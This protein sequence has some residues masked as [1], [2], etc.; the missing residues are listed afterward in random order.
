MSKFLDMVADPSAYDIAGK[1][2]AEKTIVDKAGKTRVFSLARPG[3]F[4]GREV[5]LV[6]DVTLKKHVEEEMLKAQKLESLGIL[7]GGIAHDFNNLLTSLL[8]NISIAKA[9]LNPESEARHR[10]DETERASNKAI[11]LTQQLLTF[12]KGGEPI[13]KICNMAELIRDACS[14]SLSGSNVN[15]QFD[16]AENL[17]SAEVDEGQINRVINNLIINAQQAMPNGGTIRVRACNEAVVKAGIP[18]LPSGNYVKISVIDEGV[19]IKDEDRA[20]IFDPYFSTKDTGSGLGLAAV[21]SII[22]RHDGHIMVESTPGKG[23][24][25]VFY[26]PSSEEAAHVVSKKE[27]VLLKGEGRILVMDDEREIRELTKAMLQ[28]LGYQADVA[29]DGAQAVE[30]YAEAMGIKKPYDA[31][32]LDLTVPG[33]MSGLKARNLIA[34]FDP[35][36]KA[37]ASSGYS[38]DAV[39]ANHDEYGFVECAPKP[40]NIHALGR[41]LRNVLPNKGK[42]A[43]EN[44]S[45]KERA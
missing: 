9:M 24:T 30:M 41:I 22:K 26:L 6:Q 39:L 45:T 13:K 29:S 38:N 18:G 10:L 33:G 35:R 32:I 17:W 19:G 3:I 44:S 28:M 23:A 20:R 2:L 4:A 1:D 42:G 11:R 27:A 37:I 15:C 31:V 7:A 36:V 16:I 21:F 8:G 34:E 25:F 43:Q 40:Y 14:F 5:L 12:S